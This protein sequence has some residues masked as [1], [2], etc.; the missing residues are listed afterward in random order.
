MA[1]CL[2]ISVAC[3]GT[4]ASAYGT[5]YSPRT[6]IPAACVDFGLALMMMPYAAASGDEEESVVVFMLAITVINEAGREIT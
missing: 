2:G 6:E 5:L 3:F 4:L 1:M